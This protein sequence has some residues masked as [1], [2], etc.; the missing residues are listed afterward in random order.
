MTT[1]IVEMIEATGEA[2]GIAKG[3]AEGKAEGTINALLSLVASGDL[4]ADTARAR[5]AQWLDEGI[6]PQAFFDQALASLK[7]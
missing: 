5:L 1:N 4:S 6:I 7:A 3:K 2:K